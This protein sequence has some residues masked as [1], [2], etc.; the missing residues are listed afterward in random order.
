MSND[1]GSVEQHPLADQIAAD[2]HLKSSNA[3]KRGNWGLKFAKISPP[4]TV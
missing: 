1:E 4:G 3:L 2:K